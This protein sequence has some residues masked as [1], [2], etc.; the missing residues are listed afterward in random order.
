MRALKPITYFLLED[1]VFDHPDA[2]LGA[3][4]EDGGEAAGR[5]D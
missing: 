2:L 1:D 5:P 4:V 3:L